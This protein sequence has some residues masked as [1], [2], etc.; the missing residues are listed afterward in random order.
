MLGEAEGELYAKSNDILDVWF[1]SGST[2]FHVLRGS[3]PGTTVPDDHG[4]SPEADLYLEGH[5]QHRGWFH[6]S[7]LIACAIEGHAPYRGLLTHGF[8]VDS[9]GRKM[10][11]SLGNF[12]GLHETTAKL[13]AEII[14]LWCASTDYSGDLAI[15]DKVLARVVDAYRRIRNTLRFLLANT[16]D[17]DAASD[18]VPLA[19]M[20]EIDRWALS[21]TA[22]LQ[23]EIAGHFDAA[24][25]VYEGGH[26]GVYEFHPV[27]SKLQVFC[28]EDLGAFYLDILKDRLYTTAP[29]SPARR[30]A[31]TALSHIAHAMLR[32]MAPFLSFTAEEAWQVFGPKGSASIFTESYLDVRAWEDE[33]LL[34]RWKRI[35]EVRAE[36]NRQ[37]ELLRS[38]GRIGSSLQAE[39][40]IKAGPKRL[41]EL[42]SLGDDLRFVLI[43]SAAALVSLGDT[44]DPAEFFVHVAPSSA[45]KCERCWHYRSDVGIDP[46]HP[47]IC[48]RCT[49]NLY[50]AGEAHTVA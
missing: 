28:S 13:G 41:A 20:L 16:S 3:H 39:A 47:T 4:Q 23:A 10:S 31:Q 38:E 37:I 45:T 34:V 8:T 32:W 2:F 46:A 1:D 11:K 17:F 7:L 29:K 36:A 49:S 18:A 21:R 22:E 19:D 5:D 42:A 30:S 14:R 43:T 44:A 12:V 40:T 25:G 24:R 15:D 27:V 35:A 26:Y 9:S 48:G 50:G 6:S 33:A